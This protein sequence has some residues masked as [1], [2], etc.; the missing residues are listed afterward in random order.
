[1]FVN[2]QGESW[3]IKDDFE[4]YFNYY[5]LDLDDFKLAYAFEKVK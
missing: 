1:M 2:M 3:V 5:V 4:L